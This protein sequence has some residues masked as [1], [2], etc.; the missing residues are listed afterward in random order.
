[1]WCVVKAATTRLWAR[2]GGSRYALSGKMAVFWVGRKAKPIE[3]VVHRCLVAPMCYFCV[4]VERSTMRFFRSNRGFRVWAGCHVCT[5]LYGRHG[6]VVLRSLILAFPLRMAGT[7]NC[8]AVERFSPSCDA[9]WYLDSVARSVVAFRRLV[10]G[11]RCEEL[12]LVVDGRFYVFIFRVL[13]WFCGASFRLV[14]RR[15]ESEK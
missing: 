9:C 4:V 2:N 8:T 13:L 6:E 5:R 10:G 1:M 7:E 11:L 15:E 12:H 14:V 3:R